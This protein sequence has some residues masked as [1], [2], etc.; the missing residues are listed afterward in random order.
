MQNFSPDTTLNYHDQIPC[1][2]SIIL[3]SIQPI[4]IANDAIDETSNDSVEISCVEVSSPASSLSLGDSFSSDKDVEFTDNFDEQLL[5]IISDM[6]GEESGDDHWRGMIDKMVQSR[7]SYE[8]LL[9]PVQELPYTPEEATFENAEN[10]D[11]E[12]E[13]ELSEDTPVIISKPRTKAV[14]K[15]N[16]KNLNRRKAANKKAKSI[17][18]TK[19]ENKPCMAPD[20]T[21]YIIIV[22]K[23]EEEIADRI[24]NNFPDGNVCERDRVNFFEEV[25][26]AP[27]KKRHFKAKRGFKPDEPNYVLSLIHI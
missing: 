25:Y 8:N 3:S 4:W 2:D 13:N 10:Q 5:S 12:E 19:H 7:S 1:L 22:G 14:R 17:E 26:T 15:N 6:N 27:T 20:T 9:F 23:S 16:N 21:R 24:K 18:T 11:T